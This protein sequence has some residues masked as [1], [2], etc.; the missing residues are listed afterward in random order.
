MVYNK[1]KIFQI[2]LFIR[3]LLICVLIIIIVFYINDLFELRNDI[4]QYPLNSDSTEINEFS[5]LFS[6]NII[7]NLKLN[8]SY[9]NSSNLI[10]DYIYNNKYNILIYKIKLDSSSNNSMSS[11]INENINCQT[12]RMKGY[13]NII[14]Q[15]YL[16]ISHRLGD[17]EIIKHIYICINSKIANKLINNDSIVSYKFSANH[18]SITYN[19]KSISDYYFQAQENPFQNKLIP[20]NLLFIRRLYN[21]YILIMSSK[22]NQV[23]DNKDLLSNLIAFNK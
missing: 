8:C 14:E 9:H 16:K 19:D 17:N 4:R 1:N 15:D 7:K 5:N 23:I 3:S 11:I 22:E 2:R 20:I 10:S 18:F 12:K 13:Y 21:V 6:I